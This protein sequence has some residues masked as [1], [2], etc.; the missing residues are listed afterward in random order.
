MAF[1]ISGIFACA[2][3]EVVE[4]IFYFATDVPFW[5]TWRFHPVSIFV[6]TLAFLGLLYCLQRM[7]HQERALQYLEPYL[8]LLVFSGVNLALKLNAA[9]LLPGALF[10]V[11]WSVVQVRRLRDRKPLIRDIPLLK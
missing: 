9:W 8:P 11:A 6:G 5:N 7:N 4:D 3:V 10:S 1:A 2:L